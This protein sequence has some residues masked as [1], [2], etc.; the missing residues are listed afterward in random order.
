VDVNFFLK[1]RSREEFLADVRAKIA[2]IPGIAATV[3]QP[4]GHRID[5]MISGTRANIAIKL[6]GTDL[7]KMFSI[8]NEVK[9][10]IAD[11]EGLVDVN[12]DQQVEIPQ[13]QIRANREM[14]LNMV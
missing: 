10:A 5:H 8:G 7:N 4:L 2:G 9:A 3:G 6:F 12:V 13:L 1:E 11:V 14:R